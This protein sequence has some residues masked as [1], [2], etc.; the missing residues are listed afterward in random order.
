M[1]ELLS[2]GGSSLTVGSASLTHS[3][4]R[5][6]ASL[7]YQTISHLMKMIDQQVRLRWI[8][9]W[10]VTSSAIEKEAI[11][12]C[13]LSPS[14]HVT[15]ESYRIS[16]TFPSHCWPLGLG[17][18]LHTSRRDANGSNG[19]HLLGYTGTLKSRNSLCVLPIM[20]KLRR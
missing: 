10:F 11:C 4:C 14:L 9:M 16:K 15:S 5:V 8:H 17:Y 18:C 12:C 20:I 2:H 3:K 13:M 19:I 7:R 6:R 1:I